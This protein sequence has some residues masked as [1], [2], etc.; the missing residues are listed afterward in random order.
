[1]S[2]RNL[3][4]FFEIMSFATAQS[5]L[6]TKLQNETFVEVAERI[7]KAL[8]AVEKIENDEAKMHALGLKTAI[9]E[10]HK[11]AL[12]SIVKKL[13]SDERGKELLFELVDDPAVLAVLQLH[14]IVKQSINTKILQTLDIVRP[15]MQSHGGDVEFVN[16]E[17]SVAYVR[18]QGACNGCSQSAVTLR[19]GVEKALMESIPEIKSVQVLPNEP[20]PALIQ[21]ESL[22]DVKVKGWLKTLRVEEISVGK[23]KCFETETA[24]VLII[25]IDNRLSAYKNQCPHQGLPLDGGMLEA[26]EGVLSCP[27][28]GFKFDAT[29][30]ECMTSPQVQLET[31]PLRI[32][33]GVIWVRPS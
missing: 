1:M 26:E 27:W 32:E 21:I 29:S 24:K 9:E 25:N 23:M 31:Y 22:G 28:H 20:S 4:E 13:K 7:D 17:D 30:G 5:E 6:L 3:F 16:Y 2:A 19:E 12:T 33:N 11:I 14:G 8:K 18:L 10:F 15:F